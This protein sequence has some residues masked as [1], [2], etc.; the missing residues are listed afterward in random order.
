MVANTQRRSILNLKVVLAP[1]EFSLLSDHLPSGSVE[2]WAT[3]S[4]IWKLKHCDVI[5]YGRTQAWSIVFATFSVKQFRSAQG[6]R[7]R[8]GFGLMTLSLECL[9]YVSEV[10]SAWA[11]MVSQAP[12]GFSN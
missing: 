8:H 4:C 6:E 1:F 9:T 12:L 10:W 5:K 3:P 7:L 11:H 2:Q